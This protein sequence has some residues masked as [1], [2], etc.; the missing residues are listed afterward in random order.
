MCVCVCVCLMVGEEGAY[1][2]HHFHFSCLDKY[3]KTP[4][5]GGVGGGGAMEMCICVC[6]C[7]CVSV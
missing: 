2:G 3:M 1:Y 7:V 4:P 5:F 6:V